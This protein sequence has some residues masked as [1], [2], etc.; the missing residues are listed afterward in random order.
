[1]DFRET[2]RWS[3]TRVEIRIASKLF[4]LELLVFFI[5]AFK[6]GRIVNVLKYGTIHKNIR[7]INKSVFITE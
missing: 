5:I 1:M 2:T 7:Q 4:R 3:E 6:E